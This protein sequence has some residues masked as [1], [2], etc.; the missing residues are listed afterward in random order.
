VGSSIDL[1]KRKYKHFWMLS[2]NRHDN[3]FLQNSYNLYGK[4]FFIFEIVETCEYDTLVEKENFYIKKYKSGDPKFGYNLCLVN[5]FRR[6]TYNEEVKINLSKYNLSKNKNFKL[7]KMKN[8]TNNEEIIFD[9][10][11]DCANYLIEFGFA[12]GKSRNVRCKISECLRR[13][14]VNNGYNG[15]IRKICYKHIFNIIN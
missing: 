5:E 8:T 12:N 7:F 1:S 9:N 11:V 13:K 14:K 3:I 10:L 4:D 2:N 6:N 15:S